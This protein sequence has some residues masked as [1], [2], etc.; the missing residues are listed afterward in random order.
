MN[1]ASTD[2]KYH[3]RIYQGGAYWSWTWRIT[4]GGDFVC[5]GLVSRARI[6]GLIDLFTN[7][8]RA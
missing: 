6:A 2:G 5:G 4:K 8:Q 1:K 7:L 3:L